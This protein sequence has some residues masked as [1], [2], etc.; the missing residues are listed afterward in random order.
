MLQNNTTAVGIYERAGFRIS[1]T[2]NCFLQDPARPPKDVP[3]LP[4]GYS[5][6]EIPAEEQPP[7]HDMWDFNPSWQNSFESIARQQ[8]AFTAFGVFEGSR[9]IG[10]GITEP[11]S[12]D[13]TQLAVA[14]AYRRQGIGSLILREL[15]LRNRHSSVKAINVESDCSSLISLLE[16][17]GIP[18]RLRQYEM[19]REIA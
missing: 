14:P 2:F 19:I 10:Y 4:A 1:R 7:M 5:L 8:E 3:P 6:Q 16:R 9:L 13:I 12:G 15:L 11:A 18:F 17:A